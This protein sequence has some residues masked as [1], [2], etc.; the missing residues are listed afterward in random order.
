MVVGQRYGSWLATSFSGCRVQ[1]PQ[2]ARL[3]RIIGRPLYSCA[4]S[5]STW[6]TTAPQWLGLHQILPFRFVQMSMTK[7]EPREANKALFSRNSMVLVTTCK[8]GL[9][10]LK[11][12]VDQNSDSITSLPP[13]RYPYPSPSTCTSSHYCPS[14]HTSLISYVIHESPSSSAPCA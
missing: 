14:P 2:Q 4:A 5:D 3:E 8:Y 10:P 9:T 12:F 7:D 1:S 11:M 13:Q 6:A